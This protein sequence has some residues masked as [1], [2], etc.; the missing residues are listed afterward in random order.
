MTEEKK[1]K[2]PNY[3]VKQWLGDAPP[4][5]QPTDEWIKANNVKKYDV[6]EYSW[7]VVRRHDEREK[8]E[9]D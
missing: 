9:D 8:E 2:V 7:K 1:K 6:I 4:R 5:V 3:V